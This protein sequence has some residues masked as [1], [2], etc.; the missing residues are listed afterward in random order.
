[1]ESFYVVRHYILSWSRMT[2]VVYP[3][4]QYSS[5]TIDYGSVI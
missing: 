1:M 4:T 3:A 5:F 2:L